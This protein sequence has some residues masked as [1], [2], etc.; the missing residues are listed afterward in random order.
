MGLVMDLLLDTCAFIWLCSEPEKYA[1]T[2]GETINK[3]GDLFLSDASIFEMAVKH[4]SG[5][6]SLPDGPR[7][8]ISEQASTWGI[9]TLPLSQDD[10][11][12]SSELPLHHKDPFDRLIIATAVNRNLTILTNDKLFNE[13]DV[14]CMPVNA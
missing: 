13:Y 5:K 9:V 14:K 4:A 6:L 1:D 7:R 10:I 12:L 11:F 2:V 8:W 3:A